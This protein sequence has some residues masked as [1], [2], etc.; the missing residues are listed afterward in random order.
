MI[1]ELTN[2]EWKRQKKPIKID[3]PEEYIKS[4]DLFLIYRFDGIDNLINFGA[5]SNVG[6]TTIALR[7]GKDAYIC[8][9]QVALYFPR[10]NI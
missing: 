7:K 3:F 1:K 10:K 9:S 2:H 6:H 5:G 8:E 4:G